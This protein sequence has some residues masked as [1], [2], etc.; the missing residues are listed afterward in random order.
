MNA[1]ARLQPSDIYYKA[2]GRLLHCNE[3]PLYDKKLIYN[4][5]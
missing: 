5:L 3:M 1:V 4:S 2:S